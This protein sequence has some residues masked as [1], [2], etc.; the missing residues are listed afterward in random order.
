[1][2]YFTIFCLFKFR[3]DHVLLEKKIKHFKYTLVAH[4]FWDLVNGIHTKS[5]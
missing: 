2:Y 3:N 4:L 5:W 1:M